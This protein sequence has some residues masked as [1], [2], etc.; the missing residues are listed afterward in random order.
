MPSSPPYARVAEALRQP[1]FTWY[2]LT[3]RAMRT[4]LSGDLD[5]GER[6]AREHLQVGNMSGQVDA[7][8]V[9]LAQMSILW[10]ERPAPGLFDLLQ[11]EWTKREGR[12]PAESP[13]VMTWRADL[14]K[15]AL[16]EDLPE[17]A[18]AQ[19]EWFCNAGLDRIPKMSLWSA[20]VASLSEGIARLGRPEDVARLYRLMLPH[21]AFTVQ[22]GGAVAC[23]GAFAHYLGVLA[24][25]LRQW[26]AADRHFAAAVSMHERMGA[27]VLLT[28]TR[29]EWAGMLLA[30]HQQGDTESAARLLDVVDG[31]ATSLGLTVVAER[32]RV[33]RTGMHDRVPTSV[34]GSRD[35]RGHTSTDCSL[36]G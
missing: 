1:R 7:E 18:R 4:L 30:R 11:A 5:E 36:P 22:I 20:T 14:L 13:Q 3:R 17:Q 33:L 9:F 26:D 8:N 16:A 12:L 27:R 29:L 10:Q 28:R 25:A 35:G 23:L 34:V 32:S 6:L 15:Q 21:A 24:T 19:V 2:A 31:S